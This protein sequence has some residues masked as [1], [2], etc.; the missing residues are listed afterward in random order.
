MI[1][2][3]NHC[4]KPM[5]EGMTDLE[6]FYT[7]EGKCFVEEMNKRYGEDNWKETEDEGYYGGY[8]EANG[9]D[10]G[11]FW[12]TW[13]DDDEDVNDYEKAIGIYETTKLLTIKN[14]F[15]YVP[16]NIYENGNLIYTGTVENIPTE[17]EDYEVTTGD[18]IDNRIDCEVAK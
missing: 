17:L 16:I 4:G 3:C 7:H 1:R 11:I 6:D 10:T 14:V 13:G 18:I 5:I 8:Y 2:I 12:T 15:K 9:D